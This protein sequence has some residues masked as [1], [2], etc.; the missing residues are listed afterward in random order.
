MV[1]LN[2]YQVEKVTV[3]PY[4]MNTVQDD[5][6]MGCCGE[7]HSDTAYDTGEEILLESEVE[8]VYPILDIVRYEILS[9]HA[10]RLRVNTFKRRFKNWFTKAYDGSYPKVSLVRRL[11][12]LTG[13]QYTA[14]D[15]R[16]L[17]YLHGRGTIFCYSETQLKAMRVESVKRMRDA[18][19]RGELLGCNLVPPIGQDEGVSK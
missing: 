17:E 19:S 18:W 12:A 2:A 16:V 7:V 14:L 6:H 1:K 11:R 5:P 10:W 15:R 4:C 13:I 8:L 3:C 9:R